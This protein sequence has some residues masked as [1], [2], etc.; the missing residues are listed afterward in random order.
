MSFTSTFKSVTVPQYYAGKSVF[1]T[2]GTGF[3]GKVLV[4]KLLRGCPEIKNIYFMIRPKK[5]M[6]CEER[7]TKVLKCPVTLV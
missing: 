4:E 3:I 1:L 7:L 2:G 6:S 5:G